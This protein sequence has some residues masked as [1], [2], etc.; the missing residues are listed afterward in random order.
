[1]GLLQECHQQ[2]RGIRGSSPQLPTKTDLAT[3]RRLGYLYGSLG[4]QLR[5]EISGPR[6]ASMAHKFFH[7]EKVRAKEHLASSALRDGAQEAHF[8]PASSQKLK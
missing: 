3:I 7:W 2:D 8:C 4:G 1:M 5:G 6:E